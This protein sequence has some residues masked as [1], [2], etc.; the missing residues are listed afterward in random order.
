MKVILI[1]PAYPYRGGIAAFT[2]RL[3]KEYV[4]QAVDVE[5]YTFTLQYP[6][7]LFPGKTQFSNSEAPKDISNIIH[8]KINSINPFNWRKVAK[9]I[10]KKNADI[11][12]FSYWM[13]FFAPCYSV[14]AKI[15]E[16]NKVSKCIGLVHN[17]ISHEKKGIDIIFAPLFVRKMDGFIA[18]SKSVLDDICALD[19]NDKSKRFSP[20]PL[21]DHYGERE[22]REEA[23]LKLQFDDSYRYMLFFGLVRAYKGLDLLLDA[24]ADERFKDLKVKLIVAGEFYDEKQPYLDKIEQHCLKDR[25]IICDSYIPDEKVK[26][27]FNAAD[28]IV[29]P[30]KSATQSG[31]T[32]VAYHFEKPVLVTDVGGL[33]EIIP[34]GYVGYVV[35]PEVNCISDALIDFYSNSRFDDFKMNIIEEKKKYSWSRLTDA[36]MEV[37]DD[38]DV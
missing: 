4:S 19:R 15:I 18:L 13:S 5:V 37:A 35:N 6:S 9:E 26:D 21:Y 7:L 11:V 10:K 8:R 31:V 12:I 22:S 25:V 16:K 36:I 17:M 32:Q 1:G 14:M 28:I 23:L 29:Q 34:D 3:A 27:Y 24:F 2:D 30:Y 20:H 38:M 33:K